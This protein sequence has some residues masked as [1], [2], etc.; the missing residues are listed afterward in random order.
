VGDVEVHHEAQH[1]EVEDA[2]PA[3]LAQQTLAPEHQEDDVPAWARRCFA[4]KGVKH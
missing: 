3:D 1:G 4:Q 2:A